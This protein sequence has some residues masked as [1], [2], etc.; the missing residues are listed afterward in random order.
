MD[1]SKIELTIIQAAV[2]EW[3]PRGGEHPVRLADLSKRIGLNTREI[4]SVIN[5]LAKSGIPI[6]S[7][8]SGET[9][10]IFIAVNEA[11]RMSGLLPMQSQVKDMA[12]RIA[13]VE[14]ADL[15]RWA[16][17]VSFLGQWSQGGKRHG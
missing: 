9:A 7:H 12:E 13:A 1:K 14:G 15:E 2:L 10:G 16:E 17:S 6:V 11:E 8:R 4:H 5:S 3:I